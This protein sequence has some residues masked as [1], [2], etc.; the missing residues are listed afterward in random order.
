[1]VEGS[2]ASVHITS[3]H[4]IMN[5]TKA[6]LS[7]TNIDAELVDKIVENILQES[8][9]AAEREAAALEGEKHKNSYDQTLKYRNHKNV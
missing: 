1:M 5:V 9:R 4:E 3:S 2:D 7:N 6:N 8:T